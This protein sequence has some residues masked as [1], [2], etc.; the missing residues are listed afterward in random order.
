MVVLLALGFYVAPGFSP[1]SSPCFCSGRPSGRLC[2]LPSAFVA[3]TFRS[4]LLSSFGPSCHPLHSKPLINHLTILMDV[5][6]RMLCLGA[7][8]ILCS[9]RA[10]SPFSSPASLR[11]HAAFFFLLLF[12]L[13][14][15]TLN[16]LSF[17]HGS[18]PGTT[19]HLLFAQS[20]AN[21]P[22]LNSF[23]LIT[24]QQCWGW[25]VSTVFRSAHLGWVGAGFRWTWKEETIF[26]SP[27]RILGIS[28]GLSSESG[29]T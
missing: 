19:P 27:R 22:I 24:M 6:I 12:N 18:G 5:A 11:P 21:C 4:A 26:S 3:A 25:G 8:E 13:Q 16:L 14:P 1:A 9:A 20:L 15:S 29:S 7:R 28:A 17:L 10:N 23:V 2:S